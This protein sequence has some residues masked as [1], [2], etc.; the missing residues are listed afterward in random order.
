ML[1][2]RSF[3]ALLAVFACANFVALVLLTWMPT[4]LYSRFHLSLA[5]AAF[6]AAVYPQLASIV[7]S[8]LGGY[9]ADAGAA[10][11]ARSDWVLITSF[12]EWHEGSEIEP[13]VEWGD[14][15]IDSTR[16]LSREFRS[17]G[18]RWVQ[19]DAFG[20][21]SARRHFTPSQSAH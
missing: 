10:M 15:F 6:D 14:R 7:G 18:T 16:A 11:N 9:L 3:V 17:A 2:I 20:C 5:A 12:N 21:R 19:A 4:F 1:R 13:S 8:V